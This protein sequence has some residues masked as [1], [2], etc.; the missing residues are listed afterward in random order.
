[1]SL[2]F[3]VVTISLN[4]ARFLR[5]AMDSVLAQHGIELEYIVCDPG[6]TDGS[7]EIIVSYDDPRVIPVFEPDEGPA[8]GL[9]RGF[10]RASGDILYYLNS[11]DV[12][13][14]G[15]FARMADWF[16]RRPEVDVACGHAQVIDEH[17]AAIRRVWSEPFARYAVATGA[18]V[19]IQPATFIRAAAF[20]KSGGF[21]KTDRGNWD[22][23]LLTSLYLSGARIETVDD[24]LGCYRLHAGSITMS[25]RL[26]ERHHANALRNFERL[27]GR[28]IKS[29]DRWAGSL[30]RLG[31]HLRHPQRTLERLRKGPLF[32]SG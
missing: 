21:E 2:K 3:S 5:A 6:S 25:G 24:F 19:Q 4:Q 10:A 9:N 16:A 18:H 26:A 13:L 23:G 30:L 17:G 1:M 22:G 27:M 15:A 14:P 12:V 32:R 20:R 29:R 11:D 8:D 31:K 28:Q 7:R